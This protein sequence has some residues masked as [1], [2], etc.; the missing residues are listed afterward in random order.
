MSGLDFSLLFSEGGGAHQLSSAR[1]LRRAIEN[2]LLTRE[3][4]VTLIRDEESR[5]LRAGAAPELAPLFDEIIG[6]L[7]VRESETETQTQ[8]ADAEISEASHAETAAAES[9][10][11]TASALEPEAV[12]ATPPPTSKSVEGDG[13][14]E[15][16]TVDRAASNRDPEFFDLDQPPAPV[17]WG[18]VAAILLA[19]LVLLVKCAGV[20]PAPSP[21]KPPPPVVVTLYVTRQTNVRPDVRAREI[22]T[23]ERGEV[24]R[25]VI[26]GGG[27]GDRWLR[28][29][30][31]PHQGRW[32]W[33]GNLSP[34]P[35]PALI[36]RLDGAHQVLRPGVLRREGQDG[37]F[38]EHGVQIGDRL[39]L[40]AY[41]ADDQVEVQMEGG[42]VGY[43][44]AQVFRPDEQAE[45][46]RQAEREAARQARDAARV[47][48]EENRRRANEAAN[49]AADAAAMDV[50]RTISQADANWRL[51]ITPR[52]PSRLNLSDGS[53]L[54]ASVACIVR[55]DGAMSDCRLVSEQPRNS[56][57]GAAALEAARSSRHYPEDRSRR[58]VGG[59]QVTL[60][61]EADVGGLISP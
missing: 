54:R 2:G 61:Y 12:S 7:S 40:L 28:V 8:A 13:R 25:G 60:N 59:R 29:S 30:E 3:T 9:P 36:E 53:T 6:A 37:R 4:L 26:Q 31:G 11:D 56:G 58:P 27:D 24:L 10:S 15:P 32:V 20:G 39:T 49:A 33:A 38:V 46:Q 52:L 1:S 22:G 55:D 57:Y 23:V 42:G 5:T 44:P 17:V 43:L 35:R 47:A 51:R 14:L 16:E 19:I 45:A 48:A 50:P 18:G 21:V 34:S 41:V